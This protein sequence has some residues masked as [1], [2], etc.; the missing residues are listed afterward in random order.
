MAGRAPRADAVRNRARVL[1]VAAEV[2]ATEG[3]S[4]PVQEIARRAGV[5]TGTVSRHFPT[6]LDLFQAI[7][8]AKMEELTRQGEVLAAQHDPGTAFLELFATMVR[9]GATHQGLAEALG[10]AGFD[11]DALAA[12]AGCDLNGEVRGLLEQA[13]RAGT[14][15]AD[16][17]HAD[18]KA[19]MNG[20]LTRGGTADELTPIIAVVCD[21]LRTD[22]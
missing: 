6:K 15:R 9:A 16:V 2:F 13:Q 21:G 10:G 7:L 20:C 14:I 1:E 17:T 12:Q 11:L 5:G 4:V 19:L 22:K 8:L 3:L 18:V